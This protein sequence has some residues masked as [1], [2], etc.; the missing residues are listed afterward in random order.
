MAILSQRVGTLGGVS[1]VM[2]ERPSLAFGL[3]AL[4]LG[5]ILAAWLV[6]S[7]PRRQ[8]I[9]EGLHH[10]RKQVRAA[11]D[12]PALTV[13]LLANPIVR[14]YLRRTGLREVSRRLGR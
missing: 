3:L 14:V 11:L 8:T 5:T 12:L 1:S 2:Q 13:K 9:R 7:F 10:S 4:P 6:S